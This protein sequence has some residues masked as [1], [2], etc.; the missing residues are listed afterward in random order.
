MIVSHHI[1]RSTDII[2]SNSNSSSLRSSQQGYWNFV[3][4]QDRSYVL[5]RC[6][7]SIHPHYVCSLLSHRNQVSLNVTMTCS[8]C[9]TVSQ[10]WRFPSCSCCCSVRTVC[11][12]NARAFRLFHFCK[13]TPY[14]SGNIRIST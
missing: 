9:V 8:N 6:L 4:M 2:S 3:W 5:F 7:Y 10:Y 11:L 1:L 12:L 13:L 14:V